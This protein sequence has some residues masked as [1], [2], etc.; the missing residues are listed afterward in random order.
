MI[1]IWHECAKF[2]TS[3]RLADQVRTIINKVWFSDIELLEIHKKKPHK[4]N[5]NT[6][7]DPSSGVKQKQYNEKELQISAN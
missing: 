1:E 5:Y 7:S 4:Q 6:V 2:Q 3:Q